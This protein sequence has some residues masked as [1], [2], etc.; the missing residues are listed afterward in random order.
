[1]GNVGAREP[2]AATNATARDRD[3]PRRAERAA[4]PGKRGDMNQPAPRSLIEAL[5]LQRMACGYLG[6]A[7]YDELL[8][9]TV[10]EVAAGGVCAAILDA[11]P[12]DPLATALPLRFLGAVHRL[13][14]EGRAPALAAH[15]PSAG[16]TPGPGLAADFLAT[17]AEH[18]PAVD[19]LVGLGVQTNEVGR[20]AALVGGFAIV[21]RR[22]GR[23]L[24]LLEV[25]A[26]AGLN[27]RWDRY[28][29]DTGRSQ[30]GDRAS[31]V[32]FEGVWQGDGVAA[33]ELAGVD[34]GAAVLP[35]LGGVVEVAERVGCDRQPLDP[36]TD[37][38]RLTLRSYLWPD[39][40][41]RRARLDAAL[42]IAARVPA[43]VQ[44]SDLGD[45]L[46][47]R[48]ADRP[49]G[50]ATVVYHSSVWQ[51]VGE[52]S[53]SR[54]RAALARAGA[55]ATAASPLAWLRLEPAGPVSDIRLRW[56]PGG[57]DETLGVA[58]YHGLPVY[59]GVRPPPAGR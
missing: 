27:L 58:S 41:E 52:G 9:A 21:A 6:S 7:V 57:D 48:L 59:W 46:E 36:T 42:A 50:V 10:A 38:C 12:G 15:Y 51:Y 37:D 55:A 40:T 31:A 1:M 23:P 47:D 19:E 3:P 53:R 33:G 18:R 2:R 49:P 17:V 5:E 24:R 43:P 45:W 56:W 11:Q 39:Q 13:V 25:G 30:L 16:G 28:W 26:S 20:S 29:F 22:G 8:A 34:A 54:M 44:P 32:R 35:D 14:L 4:G